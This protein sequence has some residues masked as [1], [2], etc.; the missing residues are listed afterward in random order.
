MSS[1]ILELNRALREGRS[2]EQREAEQQRTQRMGQ[3]VGSLFSPV[4]GSDILGS[5]NVPVYSGS[6]GLLMSPP[7]KTQVDAMAL[8]NVALNEARIPANFVGAGLVKKGGQMIN[9]AADA[10]IDNFDLMKTGFLT[11]PRNYIPNN[12]GPTDMP[13]KVNPET[14]ELMFAKGKKVV[15]PETGEVTYNKGKKIDADPTQKD[16]DFFENKEKYARRFDLIPKYGKMVSNELR[17]LKNPVEAQRLRRRVLDFAAWALEGTKQGT[18]NIL[19]PERRALLATTGVDPT[20]RQVAREALEKP[21][22]VSGRDT[23]KVISQGQQSFLTQGRVGFE[24]P[25]ESG[26]DLIR[27]LSYLSDTVEYT[28]QAYG[29]LIKEADSLG[30]VSKQDVEFF[31]KHVGNVWKG[32][33]GVSLADAPSPTINIKSPTSRQTGD[34]LY[35]FATKKGSPMTD[36][37]KIIGPDKNP[38]NVEILEGLQ[39]SKIS[40]HPS[41]G[42]TDAEI[43]KNVKKNG[44]FYIT[45]S[46]QGT[47]ITEGG[48]NYVAKLTPNGKVTVVVSDENN[49]LENVPVVGAV[50]EKAMPNR[51][52]SATP[53]LVFDLKSAKP[54][55][56]IAGVVDIPARQEVAARGTGYKS[57]VEDVA[58]LEADPRA[59][60]GAQLQNTGVGMLVGNRFVGEDEEKGR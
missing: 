19:E 20:T 26:L 36:L 28:P 32:R 5:L 8:P 41:M 51:V 21:K 2:V 15:N 18:L 39:S 48:V 38:S 40:I 29:R 57:I 35:D 43:L 11:G 3:A 52:I 14:G 50:I 7:R 44:G 58:G 60:R 1:D 53:P 42:K 31:S 22:G 16:I 10:V 49:F 6:E 33:G 56:T 4:G 45:G 34:H 12:Y 13:Q 37:K 24:G 9:K 30:E 25:S 46:Y 23:S 27:R 47:A 54:R 17:A 59:V 55:S